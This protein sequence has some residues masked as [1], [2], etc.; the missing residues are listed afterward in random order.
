M[1]RYDT[2]NTHG[3]IRIHGTNR[4]KGRTYNGNGTCDDKGRETYMG[5][6]RYV[7]MAIRK[8]NGTGRGRYRVYRYGIWECT[9]Q[10]GDSWNAL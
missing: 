6:I 1:R 4:H 9:S 2:R 8:E 5:R 10:N 3:S 7:A